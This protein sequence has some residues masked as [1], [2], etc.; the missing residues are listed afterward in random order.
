[1]KSSFFATFAI[2]LTLACPASAQSGGAV[3]VTPE[4]FNRA[5]SDL[6]FGGIVKEGGFGK[7]SHHREVI[8]PGYPIVRPNRD[9]LYSM[10]IFDLDAGP[11][12]VTLPDAGQRFMSLM[13]NDE[14]QYAPLVIYGGGS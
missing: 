10:A 14:D 5:E 12:T 4:N 9:T 7:Y 13:V 8:G 1:M 11:V 3:P 6:V 2:A